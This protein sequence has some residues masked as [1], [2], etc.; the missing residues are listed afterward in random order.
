[1]IPKFRAWWI[2]D[3]V[4]THIDTLEFLQGGIRVSDGCWHEKFL[5][6][7]V[8][9]MQ[10]T[11]LKDKNGVEIFSGDVVKLQEGHTSYYVVEWHKKGMW[12]FRYIENKDQYYPF[13]LVYNFSDRIRNE[14]I[15]N[16]YENPEFLEVEG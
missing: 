3:E 9:L 16:V 7:E 11:G 2:Q 13:D 15:G 10:S 6:D 1:M 4:M 8:I 14:V 12:V 5:G